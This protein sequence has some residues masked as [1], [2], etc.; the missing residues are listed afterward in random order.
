MALISR[1]LTHEELHCRVCGQ[2]KIRRADEPLCSFRKRPTCLAQDCIRALLRQA[3]RRGRRKQMD[4]AKVTRIG[5]SDGRVCSEC[6][7]PLVRHAADPVAGTKDEPLS[8][9]HRR[10][11]CIGA[12]GAAR[13]QRST[14]EALRLARP[15]ANGDGTLSPWPAWGD[16]SAH[17]LPPED[18]RVPLL[19]I[20]PPETLVRR[21]YWL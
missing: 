1:P 10:H 11:A 14:V 12:C 18:V 20:L 9:F 13:K 4:A 8:N 5:E 16:F 7:A 15:L 21:N 19:R 17:N 6:G 3:A 2:H